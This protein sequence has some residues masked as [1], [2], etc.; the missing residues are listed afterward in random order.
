MSFSADILRELNQRPIA[1]YPVYRKI[2]G[3]L[4]GAVLLS[5]LMYWFSIKDSF[6]KTDSEIKEETQLTTDELRSAKKTI[7]KLDFIIIER[8]GIPA[9]TWYT[10]DWI[11]YKEALEGISKKSS[12]GETQQ[13]DLGNS[14]S[15]FREIP[16]T[17]TKTTSKTTSKI[18]KINK[19]EKSKFQHLRSL[20]LKGLEEKRLLRYKAKVNQTEETVKYFEE[21]QK[22]EDNLNIEELAN[23]YACYIAEERNYAKR[24]N[25]FLLTELERRLESQREEVSPPKQQRD[26]SVELSKSSKTDKDLR[27]M[28]TSKR[29]E[30]PQSPPA[31]T[32][33]ANQMPTHTNTA[34][35]PQN[36]NTTKIEVNLSDVN[37]G[38][39]RLL[40]RGGYSDVDIR[41]F[42]DCRLT[43]LDGMDYLLSDDDLNFYDKTEEFLRGS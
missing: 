33:N 29:K 28:D 8:K 30:A 5:Q 21:L 41:R 32:R 7:K 16:E 34:S 20:I 31:S 13:S 37:G 38:V 3:S 24:L 2:T 11:A 43:I 42:W 9:K 19:K 4:T 10:I 22:L 1:Y 36:G 17:I 6:Y 15:Q 12:V 18:E 40:R 23:A 25:F 35:T 27:R 14:Q 39:V 26:K